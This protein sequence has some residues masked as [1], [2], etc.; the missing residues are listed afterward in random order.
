MAHGDGD[1]PEIID[2]REPELP[3]PEL[4]ETELPKEI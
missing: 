3:D 1:E 4:P 2:D